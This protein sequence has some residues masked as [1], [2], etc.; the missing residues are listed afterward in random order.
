[1]PKANG[2]ADAPQMIHCRGGKAEAGVEIKLLVYREFVRSTYVQDVLRTN[3]IFKGAG[4]F[5]ERIALFG[6]LAIK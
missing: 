3:A 2:I 6:E 1:M 5:Q 4:V